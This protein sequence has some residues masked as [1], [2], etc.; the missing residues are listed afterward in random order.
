M[1]EAN[2]KREYLVGVDLGGTKILAGVFD[3]NYSLVGEKKVNTKAERGLQ[4]VVERIA[5]C[6]REAVDE[7]DLQ[8][9]QVR[10]IGIG[11]PGAVDHEAGT[12]LFAPNLDWHDV[13][14]K[15]LLEK[16]LNIPV[17]VEND[18][19]ISMLGIYK[20]ELKAKP[21]HVLGVFIGT[22]IGGGIIINGEPY[23]GFNHI[24]GEIGHM[25]LDLNGPKCACG[26]QGCFEA[27]ASRTAM[28]QKIKIAVKNGQKTCLTEMLGT[29]LKEL[30]SG[31]LR[32]A[33]RRGD[34]LVETVVDE[35]CQYI[36]VALANMVNMFN[37]EVA[38]LGGGVIEALGDDMINEIIEVTQDYV[39]PGTLESLTLQTRCKQIKFSGGHFL[40]NG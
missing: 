37:P 24:A 4:V 8:M 31:D 28:F 38:V 33:L 9:S 34:K 15:R 14:L 32:K 27:Y 26:N 25:V 18:C 39:M 12:V 7:A 36:G 5:K 13:P 20:V 35:A 10:A 16:Q 40:F 30:R 19:N 2:L 1:E 17:L 6:V 3:C 11:A 23:N 22:G 29:D 21:R